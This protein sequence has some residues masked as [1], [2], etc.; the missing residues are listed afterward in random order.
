MKA[1][2][3]AEYRAVRF[4]NIIRREFGKKYRR[5]YSASDDLSKDMLDN[6]E[7]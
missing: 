2:T 5:F 4:E 3:I 1:T 6:N 7:R